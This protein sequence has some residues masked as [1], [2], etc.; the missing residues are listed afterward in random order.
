MGENDLNILSY[1][2]CDILSDNDILKL[3]M[4]LVWRLGIFRR[5]QYIL[6]KIVSSVTQGC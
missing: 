3:K 2:V 6:R 4:I 5:G 1:G